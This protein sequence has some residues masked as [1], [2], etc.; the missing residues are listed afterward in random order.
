MACLLCFPRCLWCVHM[1]IVVI[2]FY[3]VSFSIVQQLVYSAYM[4]CLCVLSMLCPCINRKRTLN[5]RTTIW[6]TTPPYIYLN[7]QTRI[8]TGKSACKRL[9]SRAVYTESTNKDTKKRKKN[10]EIHLNLIRNCVFSSK[11][12]HSV[13][14]RRMGSGVEGGS[15]CFNLLL[16]FMNYLVPKPLLL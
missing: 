14:S 4:D 11:F 6:I 8:Y 12:W 2:C 16:S 5:G 3:V 13:G 9:G 1:Y 7:S 10:V 15:L